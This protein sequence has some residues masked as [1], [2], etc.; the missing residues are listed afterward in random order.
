[1]HML[2]G[3]SST[4]Y[5]NL[6]LPVKWESGTC[7]ILPFYSKKMCLRPLTDQESVYW[8]HRLD[9]LSVFFHLHYNW[10][11]KNNPPCQSLERLQI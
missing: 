9:Q 3:I 11:Q 1:M 10:N 8:G 7:F 4:M 6:I 5:L 2:A